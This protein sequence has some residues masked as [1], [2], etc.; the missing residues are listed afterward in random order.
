MTCTTCLD[1]HKDAFFIPTAQPAPAGPAAPAA[2][3]A[4][5]HLDRLEQR[6]PAKGLG[7]ITA[8]PGPPPA[9]PVTVIG[10]VMNYCDPAI[11]HEVRFP[12]DKRWKVAVGIHPTLAP[13]VDDATLY[14]LE[15]LLAATHGCWESVNWGWTTLPPSIPGPDRNSS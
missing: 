5:F 2:F 15:T 1:S 10:G 6:V 13:T 14:H 3:D 7:A 9:I 4:H 12:P 8:E 11:F